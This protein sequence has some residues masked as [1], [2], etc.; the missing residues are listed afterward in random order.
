MLV[1]SAPAASLPQGISP[2]SVSA[3]TTEQGLPQETVTAVLQTRDEYLWV[4]TEGGLARF[5]GVKFTVFR[6]TNT[7]ALASHSVH[8]L[9]ED[10]SGVLWIAT[11]AGVVRYQGGRFES[12]GLTERTVY[13]MCEDSQGTLWLA[14]DR[15][16]M[17]QRGSG[18]EP[19]PA[20]PAAPHTEARVLFADKEGRVWI[21]YTGVP[22]VVCAES[23]QFKTFT[24]DGRL[25]RDV[26]AIAQ[27][28]DGSLWFGSADGLVQWNNGYARRLNMS[29][30]LAGRRVSCLHVDANGVL[31]VASNGLQRITGGEITTTA[32]VSYMATSNL[33][34]LTH[35]REG[36]LWAGAARDGLL[37]VR[38]S[39]SQLI[40]LEA[41]GTDTGFRTVMQGPDGGVW[42]AQGRKGIVRL[43]ADGE[44]VRLPTASPSEADEI[45]GV[46]AMPGGEVFVGTRGALQIWRDDKVE[47]YP[48]FHDARVFFVS[49]DGTLWIGVRGNGIVRWKNG[50][51]SPFELPPA[52]KDCTPSSFAETID[53][54][55]YVGTWTHGLLHITGTEVKVLN[56]ES[57]SLSNDIRSVYID[58]D[59]SVWVGMR[60]LG[61]AL[62]EDGQLRV[63]DW[64]SELIDQRVDSIIADGDDNLWLGTPRGIFMAPRAELL[65]AMHNELLPTRIHLVC[66]TE[67]LRRSIDDLQCF[68]NVWRTRAGQVWYAASRGILIADAAKAAPNPRPPVVHIER[69]LAGDHR[70]ENPGKVIL[71]AGTS[72]LLIEY[73]GLS[74]SGPQRVRFQYRLKGIDT[75]WIDAGERRAAS[76]ASLPPGDYEFQVIARN[77][78]GVWNDQGA[79][80]SITQEAYFYQHPGWYVLVCVMIGTGVFA[81]GRWRITALRRDKQ[82]LERA[83]AERTSELRA[84]KE[85]A[86][87]STR[88]KSEFLQSIS[89]EIRN[90]L[91]GVIG[92]V[93]ALREASVDE[94]QNE[95]F[96]SLRACAKSLGR[97]FEEVL[98]FARLEHGHVALRE[99]PFSLSELIGDVVALF[100]VTEPGQTN[101][102]LVEREAD[103][104]DHFI[105]DDEKIQTILENF[106]SNAV[107]HAPGS[108]I[109][110]SVSADSINEVAA[111][112]T[113]AVTDHGEGIPADEQELVFE[114]FARGTG[115]KRQRAAGTGLGLATCRALAEL[116]DGHVGLDSEAGSGASF[117]LT[118]RLKRDR[119]PRTADAPEI[120]AKSVLRRA[121]IIEDQ[122]YNQIVMHRMAEKL[123]FAVDTAS[124]ATEAMAHLDAQI[125]EVI[126]LDWE[127]PDMTG[128]E[129]AGKI[130]AH[131]ANREA[132]L[133]ATTAHDSEDIRRRCVVA[134]FDDFAL[135]PIT[136]TAIAR[137]LEDIRRQRLTAGGKREPVLDTRVFNLVGRSRVDG[138]RKAS[139][140]YVSTLDQE[141]R[142]LD[143]ARQ[144]DDRKT[145]TRVAHRLKTHAGLVGANDLL[146]SVDQLERG[147]LTM[148][149]A[150]LTGVVCEVI[151]HAG[152][153]RDQLSRMHPPGVV[154]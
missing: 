84:A 66:L 124:N 7:P 31:W 148:S 81:I 92:L 100:R 56:R 22:G 70:W 82:R 138:I 128:E 131:P 120:A 1:T 30:G 80:L 45:L 111:N 52:V 8:A 119:A 135:K 33:N 61:L 29:D 50:V 143:D 18:F 98:R 79:T 24:A 112:I 77:A 76:Y 109:E 83:I 65:S 34:C 87:A 69:V 71:S 55:L 16:V 9:L 108:P 59:G 122:S 115:A 113:F 94:R 35:D 102:I 133:L 49:R 2:H 149:A 139:N 39:P 137:Q 89:H 153:L 96:S 19:L 144:S 13:S 62:L 99:T 105:G 134:G 54:D 67:G 103:V 95:L 41:R 101:K 136:G 26:L 44:V 10:K 21:G 53:G 17:R 58:Q 23:D 97:V 118:L 25:S 78:D 73:A 142:A 107:K 85:L 150:A 91:N 27:T 126:F 51:F 6:T 14:T 110:I 152:A 72:G 93:G 146:A 47:I 151:A 88:A 36:N 154:V 28:P 129:I 130:R 75:E 4:G 43:S 147:A 132:I 20:D 106:I 68:P 145:I 121:L 116:M 46:Y 140:D 38:Q 12:A 42:L 63:A 11:E 15:G 125:Y 74:F 5:D 60:G 86:E 32:T 40:N 127:L 114:K 104:P 64:T 123:G 141:L 57:G 90:P 3:W 37:R 48:E 117:F